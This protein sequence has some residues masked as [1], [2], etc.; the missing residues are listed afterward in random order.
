MR[1]N[2]QRLNADQPGAGG[3]V[4]DRTYSCALHRRDRLATAQE[5]PVRLTRCTSRQSARPAFSRSWAI[6]PV[7]KP[8]TPALLTITSI[9]ETL[10]ANRNQ[11]LSSRTSRGSNRHPI[12]AAIAAPD[13]S[14][15]S[16]TM[17]TAPSSWKRAAMARSI[18]H[19]APVTTQVLFFSLCV[20]FSRTDC[21]WRIAPLAYALPL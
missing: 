3:Y 6:I 4:D 20:M 1:R 9:A 18:A 14:S 11:S 12:S 17:T 19:A 8:V 2:P 21:S 13:G 15:M 7:S 10:A 16:V 5:R